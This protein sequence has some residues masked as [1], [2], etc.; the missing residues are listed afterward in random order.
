MLVITFMYWLARFKIPSVT[1]PLTQRKTKKGEWTGRLPEP[2][3]FRVPN[4]Y[5]M[6]I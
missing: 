3:C 6:V 2:V 4:I 5:T 1:G